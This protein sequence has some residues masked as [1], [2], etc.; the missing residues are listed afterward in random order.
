DI[1]LADVF[2]QLKDHEGNPFLSQSPTEGRL[3]FGL[4]V[5]SFEPNSAKPG[6]THNSATRVCIV[7]YNFPPHLRYLPENI[8]IV[9]IIPSPAKPDTTHIN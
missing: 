3:V 9:G 2:Q 1:W 4:S 8:Y 7:C 5:N 6:Q